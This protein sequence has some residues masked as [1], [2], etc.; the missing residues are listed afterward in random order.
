M[1]WKSF[2]WPRSNLL[3]NVMSSEIKRPNDK[4]KKRINTLR[5]S[6]LITLYISLLFILFLNQQKKKKVK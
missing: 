4:K 2:R 6:G 5:V 1:Q 3:K